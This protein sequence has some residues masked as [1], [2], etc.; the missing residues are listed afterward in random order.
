[1]FGFFDKHYTQRQLRN[2][3][4]RDVNENPKVEYNG[5]H[6][7]SWYCF[8]PRII[9]DINYFSKTILP[10]NGKRTI[11]TIS[12]QKIMV[13]DPLET[14]VKLRAIYENS[15]KRMQTD[16][17][18]GLAINL[19]G[20]SLGNVL[21]IRLAANLPKGKVKKLVSLVGGAQLGLSA[22]DSILT[23]HTARQSGCR[24]PNEY[25]RKLEEFSPIN[26]TENLTLGSIFSRF[27]SSDLLIPFQPHGKKLAEALAKTRTEKIDVRTYPFADHSSA[28]FL[29][30]LARRKY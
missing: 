23:G 8:V 16:I 10:Q 12:S 21:S 26:Y 17:G 30:S 19:M 1:M 20:I 5:N 4:E 24:T 11:Y 27:G 13:S 3:I 7:E 6:Q 25:E 22:W 9:S 14:V 28:I 15:I 29:S 2:P 18:S